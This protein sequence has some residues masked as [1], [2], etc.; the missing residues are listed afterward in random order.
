M[1]RPELRGFEAVGAGLMPDIVIGSAAN[2]RHIAWRKLHR[3][4]RGIVKP[5]PS[6][7]LG[8]GMHSELDRAAEPQPPG[9]PGNGTS[10]DRAGGA[11]PRQVIHEQIHISI[12]MQDDRLRQLCERSD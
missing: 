10:E 9:R 1:A 11:R 8:D 2:E 7:P 5:Q 4:L 3:T 6:A 12:T